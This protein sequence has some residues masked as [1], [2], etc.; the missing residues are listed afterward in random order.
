MPREEYREL[1]V[2]LVGGLNT[3]QDPSEIDNDQLA[4]A[5]GM[6]YRP[7]L[8]GLFAVPGRSRADYGSTALGGNKVQGLGRIGPDNA[9]ASDYIFSLYGA[10]AW[11]GSAESDGRIQFNTIYTASGVARW[12]TTATGYAKMVQYGDLIVFYNGVNRNVTMSESG[13]FGAGILTPEWQ[14]HGAIAVTAS[15]SVVSTGISSSLAAGTYQLW[16]TQSINPGAIDTA[17]ESAYEGAQ[18]EITL[19]ASGLGIQFTMPAG[20][21]PNQQSVGGAPVGNLYCT[22]LGQKYPFGYVHVAGVNLASGTTYHVTAEQTTVNGSFSA[23]TYDW[24]AY[25]IVAP[26]DGVAVSAHSRPPIAYDAAIF[27]DSIVC[28]DASDR[29][30]I[31]YSLPDDPH[32]FPSTYFIPFNTDQNDALNAITVC[33]NAL[34]VFSSFYGYRVDDLPRASDAEAILTARSR[35][36]EPFSWGHGCISPRGTAVFNIFGSGQLCM[37]ICR[38]GIHI[39]DGFKTDYV[40]TDLDWASTVSI[41]NLSKATLFNYPKAHRIEFRYLDAASA[42]QCI[43]L[44]YYPSILQE[45]RTKGFPRFPMLGPRPVPGPVAVLGTLG[46]DWQVWTGSDNGATAFF[47]GT[48]TVD[49]AQLV[50]ASGTVNKSWKTKTWYANGYNADVE[51][52]DVY[53]NQAQ[54][55]ASGSYTVTATFGV[56]DEQSPYTAT[57]TVD[58][59]KKGAMPHPDLSNRGQWFN[60]RGAKNDGGAW[61]ELNSIAFVTQNPS[62]VRSGKSSV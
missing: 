4:E 36:K 30:L 19:S 45:S 22:I 27:Q 48:G 34:L 33:N 10:S 28:I 50:D 26:P 59:S 41:A 55:T 43:D 20:S 39:T 12:S 25:Q 24:T 54:T 8:I 44:Y 6:E 60:L 16:Y 11:V 7:P 62:R 23:G 53:T 31:K 46:G 1:L 29:Q 37:F 61:Q 14:L 32:Y 3:A 38:D 47:E 35:A 17:H 56:D 9:P 15:G 2:A 5:I 52:L 21:N 40:T 57:G 18:S 58:Q 49:N 13:D 42:W 51:L